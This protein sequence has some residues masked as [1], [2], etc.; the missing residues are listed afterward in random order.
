M[1]WHRANPL[2]SETTENSTLLSKI[3]WE[4]SI[5]LIRWRRCA[6]SD[7]FSGT[8]HTTWGELM[9][10]SSTW[11]Q[12]KKVFPVTIECV[13][14]SCSR[15]KG[16]SEAGPSGEIC[17]SSSIIHWKSKE[18]KGDKESW[19][20]QKQEITLLSIH[21]QIWCQKSENYIR[22]DNRKGRLVGWISSYIHSQKK[23]KKQTKKETIILC[24]SMVKLQFTNSLCVLRSWL[25]V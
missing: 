16:Q 4:L 25:R 12:K 21:S 23:K 18:K 9:A 1:S 11:R 6:D 15:E 13:S 22:S 5:W 24:N 19:Q 10:N 8:T 3:F 20:W 2:S 14:V 17:S 7:T